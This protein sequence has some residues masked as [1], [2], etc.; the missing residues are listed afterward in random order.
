MSRRL[1]VYVLLD[2]SESMIGPG[3]EGL[4]SAVKAMLRELRRNPQALE[5][6]WLSFV[7][8]DSEARQV[9]PLTP[10]ADVQIPSLQVRP[11]TSLGGALRLTIESIRKE[12]KCT[13]VTEKG[14]FR[15]LIFL[16][17]DGQP[18][19]EWRSVIKELDTGTKTRPANIYAIGC[20][21]DVDLAQLGEITDIV[22]QL[23][24]VNADGFA[25]LFVWLSASVHSASTGVADADPSALLDKLPT[26]ITK[27]DLKKVPAHDGRSR[28]IFLQ[29]H[30]SQKR[31]VYLMRYRLDEKSG[32]YRAVASHPLA[33][34]AGETAKE[35]RLPPVNSLLLEGVE[36]CPY[37]S[38]DSGANCGACNSLFCISS[39]NLSSP[40]VCPSCG[41]SRDYGESAE[42]FMVNQSTG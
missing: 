12:V 41:D 14:D 2:C 22:L 40:S 9:M 16:I 10:V 4:G 17:T 28:Q 7:T 42:G 27:V 24:K 5:T 15:P 35:F 19:D 18:T 33:T 3:I 37:C 31:G 26:D 39:R 25:K 32:R 6:V 23:D 29:V 13:T 21:A 20:G 34:V 1:P 30:C 38:N 36:A 8:F 11:G